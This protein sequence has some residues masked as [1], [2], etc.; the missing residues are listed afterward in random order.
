MSNL[1][2]CVGAG[3][4]PVPTLM[5][6]DLRGTSSPLWFKFSLGSAVKPTP[7]AGRV[8]SSAQPNFQ[9]AA[10]ENAHPAML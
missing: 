8:T 10:T 1:R 9:R 2:W 5:D 7:L 6:T 3:E 4:S